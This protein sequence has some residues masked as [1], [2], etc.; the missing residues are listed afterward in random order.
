MNAFSL[1]CTYFILQTKLTYSQFNFCENKPGGRF[2][3]NPKIYF[4]ISL[5]ID[6]I[7]STK[8]WLMKRFSKF[9]LVYLRTKNV[10]TNQDLCFSLCA[11]F[12]ICAV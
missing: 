12:S 5:K 10:L 11:S 7:R 3:K 1:F 8:M 2:S 6:K 9:V 4:K